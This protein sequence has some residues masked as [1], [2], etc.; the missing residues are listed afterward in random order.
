MIGRRDSI[1]DILITTGPLALRG[2][3]GVPQGPI[4]LVIFAHG[5]GSSRLSPRN[6]HVAEALRARG[7]ATLLVDLLTESEELADRIDATLR[8]DVELLADRLLAITDWVR[9]SSSVAHLP[10][11]YFGASTGAAAALLAASRRPEAV[12]AVVSRGGRP[13][14]AGAALP[15]VR[16]PTLLIVGSEDAHVLDLNREAIE[17]MTV[18]TQ[19]AIVPGASHLFEEPGTLDEVA[20]LASEWLIDHFAQVFAEPRR[21]NWGRQFVDRRAAGQRLA[22]ALRHYADSAGPAPRVTSGAPPH[23]IVYGLP[24]GGVP[25][26]DEIAKALGAP[27]DVWLV[28][29]IGM[30]IQPELGMGA[31]AEGAAL[32]LDPELVRWSGAS[33]RELRALVHRKAAEIRRSARLY[34]GEQ[35]AIDVRGKTAILVDDGIATGNT[36]RAAIR[37][38][39]KRGAARVVIAAPVAAAEAV[40]MLRGEA[41]E[42]VCLSTPEHL[43]AVG[44]WYQSFH[45]LSDDEVLA[46]LAEA[47]HRTQSGAQP[48]REPR[49]HA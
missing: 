7:I 27:L 49:V 45:Q 44:A 42:V 35:A 15:L 28:R 32:V 3:L 26:A 46:I 25:V 29:K 12:R 5:S 38:A 19:L 1:E 21:S 36:L 10:L 11:A 14:L 31:I 24:R 22:T 34:R 33:T 20:Q 40:D 18:P 9:R 37:G 17:R 43:I 48:T 2:C 47:R 16:A 41:D 39:K 30:P 4:G 8:F 23:V 13:D 6:R